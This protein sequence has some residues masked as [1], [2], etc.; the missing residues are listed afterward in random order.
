MGALVYIFDLFIAVYQ[1]SKREEVGDLL[2]HER[3]D[4][5]VLGDGREDRELRQDCARYN[6]QNGCG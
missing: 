1:K 2:R 4:F 6:L 3:V 5:L